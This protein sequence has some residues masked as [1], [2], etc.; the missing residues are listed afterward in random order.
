MPN[1]A[2]QYGP[3]IHFIVTSLR[4]EF[5]LSLDSGINVEQM[6]SESAA[7]Y[8]SCSEMLCWA[9][10]DAAGSFDAWMDELPEPPSLPCLIRSKMSRSFDL[11]LILFCTHEVNYDY[12][13]SKVKTKMTGQKTRN[14]PVLWF[15]VQL[16]IAIW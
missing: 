8:F 10:W 7:W 11:S 14:K 1:L 5:D 15:F 3:Y 13:F 9:Q 16:K 4:L 12:S 2:I 6:W